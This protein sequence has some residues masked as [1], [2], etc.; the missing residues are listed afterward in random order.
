MAD[1]TAHQRS[2]VEEMSKSP[3][4]ARRGFGLLTKREL[5]TDFFDA[6]SAKQL[7]APEHNPAPTPADSEGLVRV[8]YWDA[9]PYLV[10]CARVAGT[11][12]DLTLAQRSS[13]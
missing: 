5:F 7:F 4:H 10:G 13:S 12:P 8:P 1:L 9:L 2:F 6:L 11:T 3:E